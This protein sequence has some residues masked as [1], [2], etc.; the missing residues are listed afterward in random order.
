MQEFHKTNS[1]QQNAHIYKI[2]YIITQQLCQDSHQS[3]PGD[4]CRRFGENDPLK[5]ENQHNFGS[6]RPY[7]DHT[8]KRWTHH[9][10]APG[11][12]STRNDENTV[13]CI[14][15][16]A[17]KPTTTPQ[18]PSPKPNYGTRS[19]RK[20]PP[21]DKWQQNTQLRIW[22]HPSRSTD[23]TLGTYHSTMPQPNVLHTHERGRPKQHWIQLSWAHRIDSIPKATHKQTR[24]GASKKNTK[25]HLQWSQWSPFH[26]HAGGHWWGWIVGPTQTPIYI[27]QY[28]TLY[29]L[30]CACK[31]Q[32]SQHPQHNHHGDCDSKPSTDLYH[33]GDCLKWTRN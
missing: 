16:Y 18:Q 33:S 19:T 13:H 1:Q 4:A 32:P 30:Q 7:H 8:L 29:L 15:E 27:D 2:A 17:H 5:G 26:H 24:H 20:Q 12:T 22:S 3:R 28:T 9:Q 31:C 10:P 23:A 14:P 25:W 11:A 6:I 21:T